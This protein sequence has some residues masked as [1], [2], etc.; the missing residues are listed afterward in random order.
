VVRG[1]RLR[2][3]FCIGLLRAAGTAAPQ[4]KFLKGLRR[5][6]VG[7]K[8]IGVLAVSPEKVP[9]FLLHPPALFYAPFLSVVGKFVL[10]G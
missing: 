3:S 1:A 2:V 8:M 6:G 7:N 5:V 4:T 9:P 10:D